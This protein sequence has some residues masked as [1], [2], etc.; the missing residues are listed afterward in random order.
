MSGELIHLWI[1]KFRHLLECEKADRRKFEA[2]VRK[3][4]QD[5]KQSKGISY[6]DSQDTKERLFPHE[7]LFL[8]CNCRN[9]IEMINNLPKAEFTTERTNIKQYDM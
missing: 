7:F 5:L 9:R 6:P 4:E 8:L 1:K 2:H 3:V